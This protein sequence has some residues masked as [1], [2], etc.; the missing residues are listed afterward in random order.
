MRKLF[1]GGINPASRKETTRRKPLM[2]LEEPP[3]TVVLPLQMGSGEPARPLVKPGDTVA[4]GELIAQAEEGGSHVHASVSGTVAAIEP[5]PYPW[6]GE[7]MAIVIRND[8]RNTPC[9]H[10][11]QGK[12]VGQ[13]TQLELLERVRAAGIC[14]MGKGSFP[15]HLKLHQARGKA[16]TLIINAAACEPYVTADHRV[17]LERGSMVLNGVRALVEI[18]GVDRAVLAAEGNKLDAMEAMEQRVDGRDRRLSLRTIRTRY[19][20]GEEKQLVQTITGREVPPGGNILDV[21]CVMFNVATVY[22]VGEAV[23]RGRPVTHR[24]VTVSGGAVARPRNFWVPIGTPMRDLLESAGGLLEPDA[25][26]LMGGA[27][28]GVT[29]PTLDAPVTKNTNSLICLASWERASQDQEGECVR[30]GR[31][32]AACPMHLAPVFVH[33]AM[34]EGDETRLAELHV[35][36]CLEC[37]CCSYGCPVHIP[38]A[39]LMRQAKESL[40][41]GGTVYEQK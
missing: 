37:G 27:M 11:M 9:R 13:Y 28:K 3:K 34:R 17:L 20:L 29:L 12:S 1:F 26:A 15:T 38:L 8:R 35:E 18:L 30:C 36:D 23:C 16:D 19:P 21:G 24:A 6:G 5:R 39:D 40:R 7:R 10:P 2:L 33:R 4:V 14:G 32:V 22:A 31:C 41:E 25:L